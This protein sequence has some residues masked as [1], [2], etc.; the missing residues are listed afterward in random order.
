[1]GHSSEVANA[2]VRFYE[3]FAEGT[4]EAFDRIVFM[5]PDVMAIGTDP[6]EQLDD[7]D[8]WQGG[9]M[10]LPG[11]TMEAGDIQG[12]RQDGVGWIV[13]RP[14]FSLPDGRRLRT[15]LTAVACEEDDGCKLVHLHVSVAVPDEVALA[16]ASA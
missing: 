3:A 15:R 6:K 12:F 11:I 14:T 1:M 8:A 10:S 13:D 7:R 5:V 9:F 16:E 2:M 4:A